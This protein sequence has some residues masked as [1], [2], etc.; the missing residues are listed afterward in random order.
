MMSNNPECLIGLER[1]LDAGSGGDTGTIASKSTFLFI[2]TTGIEMTI[3][4][5]AG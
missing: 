5:E 1:L 3:S 2:L 4:A